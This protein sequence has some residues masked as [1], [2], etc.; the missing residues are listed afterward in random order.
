MTDSVEHLAKSVRKVMSTGKDRSP[1]WLKDAANSTTRAYAMATA[2]YR[3][4]PD[5]LIVGTKRGGTTSLFNYLL[6]HPSVLPMFP[7][8]R[9]KKSPYYFF[10]E[11]HRGAVWYRS[12]FPT[13]AYRRRMERILGNPVVAG[14]G[15]PY[16]LY[17][18][19][20][21]EKIHELM[22]DVKSIILL[23]DPVKRAYSH[24][25][26]RVGQG[27]E[28]LSF[29]DALAAESQ[30]LATE[31]DRMM[32]DRNFY[33]REH[34]FHSYRDRGI[35]LPQLQRWFE[36]FPRENVLILRSEDLYADEQ[37]ILNQTCD[38]LGIPHHTMS[39]FKQHNEQRPD[40]MPDDIREELREF[41]APHNEQLYAYLGRDFGW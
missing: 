38:F 6:E 33:S 9:G 35:Y 32:A 14:E 5:F 37:A 8:A 3:P 27:S 36:K 1:R 22:P 12:H 2:A 20:G 18:P 39:S 11:Y 19:W 30:R 7:A 29:R 31:H 15:S 13:Q 17:D 26:E 25:W 41:Y 28:P 16:Y 4:L 34:D 23:R 40:P 10:E 21:A 24:Y